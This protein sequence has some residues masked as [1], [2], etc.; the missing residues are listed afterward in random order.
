MEL[1]LRALHSA[2]HDGGKGII[3]SAVSNTHTG[4]RE[5]PGTAP[6]QS[7]PHS[8]IHPFLGQTGLTPPPNG[9]GPS[10][11]GIEAMIPRQRRRLEQI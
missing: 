9:S 8:S 1:L 6:A 5:P 7:L 11:E 4:V 2:F 10:Q 3:P